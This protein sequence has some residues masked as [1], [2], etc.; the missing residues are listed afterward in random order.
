M[1]S[2]KG[3]PLNDREERFCQEYLKDLN[4]VNAAKRA[5]YSDRHAADHAWAIMRR[6]AIAK[7]IAELMAKREK[8]TEITAD[9]VLQEV[10]RVAFSDP[11][12][13]VDASGKR[14][15][16]IDEL[17]DDLAAAVASFEIDAG[18]V[19][20]RFWDKNS[21]LEKLCKHLGLLT[22]RLHVTQTQYVAALPSEPL[23][24]DD[25]LAMV[26]R[27]GEAKQE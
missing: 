3:K 1:P 21:A 27:D 14:L 16:H 13:L 24:V 26:K 18:K 12:Q 8:R 9:R 17:P 6:P 25:W 23:S 11:R 4:A 7:R 20:Y 2:R 22:D 19:K 10:A 15:R 5:G